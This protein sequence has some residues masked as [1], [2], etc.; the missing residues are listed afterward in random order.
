VGVWR[1][2]AVLVGCAAML[3]EPADAQRPLPQMHRGS[4]KALAAGRFL[5]A[6]R[7]LPDPNFSETV[8][9][10]AEFGE[11]GAMGL[12]LNR[13]SELPVGRLLSGMKGAAARLDAVFVGGPVAPTGIVALARS[14]AEVAGAK[15][16]LDEV[17]L[18][19]T[20]PPLEALLGGG[21]TPDVFRVYL[22]YAGWS[23]SQLEAEVAL[24]AWHVFS[25]DVDVVFDADPET[26]WRRQIRRTESLMARAGLTPPASRPPR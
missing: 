8:V 25:A 26:A 6:S 4:V 7:H 21:A 16:I 2:A 17:H 18:I 15:R 1:C 12:V 10:L 24:G 5:V 13:R 20:R 22:G 3:G 23:A 19:T 11:E 14:R 9:L